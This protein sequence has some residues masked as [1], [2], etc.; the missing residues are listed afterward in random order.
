MIAHSLGLPR[1]GT[2]RLIGAHEEKPDAARSRRADEQTDIAEKAAIVTALTR[3]P[4]R[5]DRTI[6]V[7]RHLIELCEAGLKALREKTK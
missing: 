3:H 4:W 2:T 5:A 1:Q 7:S 6:A